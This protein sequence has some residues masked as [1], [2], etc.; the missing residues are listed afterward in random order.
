MCS[1][2]ARSRCAR[3]RAVAQNPEP[4]FLSFTL[5]RCADGRDTLQPLWRAPPVDHL[6]NAL[7][8]EGLQ[9]AQAI[10]KRLI[11]SLATDEAERPNLP[12]TSFSLPLHLRIHLPFPYPSLFHANRDSRCSP[13]WHPRKRVLNDLVLVIDTTHK[14]LWCSGML[15]CG[16][17]RES[18][19]CLQL[20]A[21]RNKMILL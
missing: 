4:R 5:R 20:E 2:R 1:V 14:L 9:G 8:H 17:R 11:L 21:T 19:I 12:L 13:A 10:S 3:A 15:N 7:F 6:K 18:P 16:I